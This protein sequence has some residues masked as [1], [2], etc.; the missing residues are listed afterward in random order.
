MKY[1]IELT[2]EL[3]KLE[4]FEFNGKKYYR[5]RLH[6]NGDLMDIGISSKIEN[7]EIAALE[8]GTEYKFVIALTSDRELKPKVQITSISK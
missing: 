1:E 5:A 7:S 2:A 3:F 4:D 6:D 8:V